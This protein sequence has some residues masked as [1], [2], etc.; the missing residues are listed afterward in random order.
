MDLKELKRNSINKHRLD[1]PMNEWELYSLKYLLK[2]ESNKDQN[3]LGAIKN[4]ILCM[5][6]TSDNYQIIASPEKLQADILRDNEK[7][8]DIVLATLFQWFGTSVGSVEMQKLQTGLRRVSEK[9]EALK[10][11]EKMRS[12]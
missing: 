1:V 6:V 9:K 10:D 8:V 11:L 2:K 7:I 3:L 12:G 5:D 4:Q